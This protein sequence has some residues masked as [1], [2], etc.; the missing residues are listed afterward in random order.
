MSYIRAE[1]VLPQE[2]IQ[3]IQQYVSGKSIYIPCIEK[4]D[5]GSRTQTKQYYRSRDR[6]ICAKHGR[7]I[8]VS[9]LAEEYSLSEKSIRRILRMGARQTDG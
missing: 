2:L 7:G 6:E 9:A 8:P 3:A 5:W 4:A 1:E